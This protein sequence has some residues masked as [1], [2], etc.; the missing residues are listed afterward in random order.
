MKLFKGPV[1][2]FVVLLVGLGAC[3]DSTEQPPEQPPMPSDA[4]EQDTSDKGPPPIPDAPIDTLNDLPAPEDIDEQA[5]LSEEPVDTP[6]PTPDPEPEQADVTDIEDSEQDSGDDVPDEPEC[7][8]DDACGEGLVCC[9]GRCVDL[10]SDRAHCSECNNSCPV[11]CEEGQCRRATK[12]GIGYN[13]TCAILDDRTVRCWGNNSRGELGNPEIQV[14]STHIP[15]QV[16]GIDDALMVSGGLQHTCALHQDGEVSCWGDNFYRQLAQPEEV[17]NSEVPLRIEG[18]EDAVFLTTTDFASCAV[19]SDGDVMC[20]GVINQGNRFGSYEFDPR[21]ASRINTIS[22]VRLASF[23]FQHGLWLHDNG[24]ISVSGTG[25][26]GGLGLGSRQ[27]YVD[28]P[29]VLEGLSARNLDAGESH[30]CAVDLEGDLWCWGVN[31][32]YQV[33]PFDCHACYVPQRVPG[34][35]NVVILSL[36][37]YRTCFTTEEGEA[38]CFGTS[39]MGRPEGAGLPTPF[40]NLPQDIEVVEIAVGESH[41]CVLDS[42]GQV[43]CAGNNG[44]LQ[45]GRPNPPGPTAPVE[46]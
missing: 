2:V 26:R 17:F 30:S 41:R 7:E 20:W 5:D 36:G 34:V 11:G 3:Q 24:S 4:G 22:D 14:G 45:L 38:L 23:G 16:E 15:T 35:S 9:Q 32:H 29:T 33:G 43:Y 28:E 46:W 18:V 21:I 27:F 12:L 10:L 6:A 42:H 31:D 13:H 25:H 44:N 37:R 8:E 19:L 40:S 39:W 1:S